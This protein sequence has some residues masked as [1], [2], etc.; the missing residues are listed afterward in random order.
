MDR[1]T[2]PRRKYQ[3]DRSYKYLVD[4]IEGLIHQGEF[5]P[6]EIREACMLA[7]IHYE[8][9]RRCESTIISIAAEEALQILENEFVNKRNF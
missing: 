3:K 4:A 7:C 1:L 9:R 8:E 2:T 6:S 5:T